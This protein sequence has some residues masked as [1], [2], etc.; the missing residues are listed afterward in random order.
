MELAVTVLGTLAVIFIVC[1]IV[2]FMDLGKLFIDAKKEYY[3]KKNF[4]RNK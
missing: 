4:K 3:A 2:S 1:L